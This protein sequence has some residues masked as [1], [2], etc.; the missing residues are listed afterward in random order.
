NQIRITIDEV[1]IDFVNLV[2]DYGDLPEVFQET[3]GAAITNAI[4]DE[5]T[6]QL[7]SVLP[8]LLTELLESLSLGG[9]VEVNGAY[10]TFAG[11]PNRI[12]IDEAAMNLYL[13]GNVTPNEKSESVPFFP[14]SRYTPSLAPDMS[15]ITAPARMGVTMSDDMLNRLLFAGYETGKLTSEVETTLQE[16]AANTTPFG[17]LDNRSQEIADIPIRAVPRLHEQ[18]WLRFQDGRAIF[19]VTDLETEFF[20]F[21]DTPASW[22]SIITLLINIRVPANFAATPEGKLNVSFADRPSVTFRIVEESFLRPAD[23]VDTNALIEAILPLILEEFGKTMEEVPLPAFEDY[24]FHI[25]TLT[26]DGPAQ[27][28]ITLVGN[29]QERTTPQE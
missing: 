19:E 1:N 5:L 27:D 2:I 8:V 26:F 25:D 9:V 3:L 10:L 15:G 28:Y 24:E 16:V 20:M 22:R 17:L 29:L 11:Q 7:E 21:Q 23:N 4:D 13:G 6:S 12:T 18:P 14:G